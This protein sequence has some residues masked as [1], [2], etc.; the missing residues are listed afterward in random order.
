[1]IRVIYLA[2]LLLVS[3]SDFIVDSMQDDYYNSIY[4]N[5]G[6]ALQFFNNLDGEYDDGEE[7][8]DLDGGTEN[9]WDDGEPHT[10]FNYFENDF[11]I[12][13]FISSGAI[14]SSEST[15]IA[16]FVSSSGAIVFG[17]YRDPQYIDRIK[18]IINDEIN[19]VS[20]TTIENL[21]WSS[22]SFYLISVW[23]N[24]SQI[25]IS[26]NGENDLILDRGGLVFS[27]LDLFIGASGNRERTIFESFWKG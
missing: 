3:C 16:S 22:D 26:V 27:D 20:S 6:T 11:T 2:A 17:L 18:V 10:D 1:M 9:Q 8:D 13:M 25:K 21:N 23:V 5:G 15:V 12:E 4:L 14:N 24:D 19:D 7:F